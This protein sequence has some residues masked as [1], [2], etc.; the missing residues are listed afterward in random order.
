MKEYVIKNKLDSTHSELLGFAGELFGK[1]IYHRMTS[2]FAVRSVLAEAEEPF[3]SKSDDD[4]APIGWWRGEFWG[5]WMISAVR[6]CK[7]SYDERLV[8]I[9]KDSVDKIIA[10]A[11]AD[12]YIGTY[13][14]PA[15]IFPCTEEAG[16][17]AVGFNCNFCWNIP[18]YP[19]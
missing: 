8:F 7:Y 11:D 9:I 10:T 3:Y 6:A 12:G 5:K 18:N 4:N 15:M 14:D 19:V 1:M 2:D 16:R 13:K 17:Q